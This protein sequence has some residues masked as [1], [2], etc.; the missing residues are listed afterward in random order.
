MDT[1]EQQEIR[2]AVKLCVCLRYYATRMYEKL[3]T[4]TYIIPYNETIFFEWFECS[5]NK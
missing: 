2:A 4:V 1:P 3:H 5:N